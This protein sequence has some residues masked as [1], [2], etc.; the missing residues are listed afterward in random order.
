MAGRFVFH[1]EQ[2]V[3]RGSRSTKRDVSMKTERAEIRL[4]PM[5]GERRGYEDVPVS[6]YSLMLLSSPSLPAVYTPGLPLRTPTVLQNR[7]DG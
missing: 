7:E 3:V 1:V 6:W 5:R 2:I 4:T